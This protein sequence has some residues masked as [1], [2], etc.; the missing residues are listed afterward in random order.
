MQPSTESCPLIEPLQREI[1]L[2]K[3]LLGDVFD[4]FATPQYTASNRKHAV[5][6][7]SQELLERLLAFSLCPPDNLPVVRHA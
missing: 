5:L 1:R 4:V 3:N 7:P 2:H 6:M